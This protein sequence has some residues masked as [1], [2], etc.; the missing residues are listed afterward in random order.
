VTNS[1]RL[2][3]GEQ[4]LDNG[5]TLLAVQNPNVATFACAV[6][7]DIRPGAD[8]D[9]MCGLANLVGDCLDEGTERHDALELATAVESIGGGLEGN[10]RGGMV[11]CTADN[12]KAGIELLREYV[13]HPTFPGKEV[14]RVQA[15]ILTEILADE[16][17]PRS[18]AGRRFRSEVYGAHPLGR[19]TQGT[20]ESIGAIKPKHLRAF[21]D[22]WFRPANGYV[23]AGGTD[24]VCVL[25]KNNCTPQEWPD[26]TSCR[27][28]AEMTV[29]ASGDTVQMTVVKSKSVM[30]A[31]ASAE[32]RLKNGDVLDDAN[33][34]FQQCHVDAALACPDRRVPRTLEQPDRVHAVAVMQ[35]AEQHDRHLALASLVVRVGPGRQTQALREGLLV[36]ATDGS[37]RRQALAYHYQDPIQIKRYLFIRKT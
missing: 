13:M 8:P 25:A 7:L 3:I 16:D 15:E 19:P 31:K 11:Q 24:G 18:V 17:D 37:Y 35:G 27:Q 21:H 20:R 33:H 30:S 10:A 22:T 5:L 36:L 1:I 2:E 29:Q 28:K 14:R 32:L 4:Q 9:E 6:S 23:A 26:G 34:L 12:Q